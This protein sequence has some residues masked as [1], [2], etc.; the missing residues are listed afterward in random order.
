MSDF[1]AGLKAAAA[2]L[3]STAED[4]EQIAKQLDFDY[5]NPKTAGL[6]GA[7]GMRMRVDAYKERAA[8]LRG[9]AEQIQMLRPK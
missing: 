4:F 5:K 9:Q 1:N 6:F 3:F 8:L 7:S 2:Y